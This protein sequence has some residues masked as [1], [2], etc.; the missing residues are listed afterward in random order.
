MVRIVFA[1]VVAL[2]AIGACTLL[3]EGPPDDSCSADADC[4]RAQGE[5]CDTATKRC[6]I[7]VFMD[8][9]IDAP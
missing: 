6:E 5:Y 4:F 1:L 9:G 2:A 8:A 7:R 3:D